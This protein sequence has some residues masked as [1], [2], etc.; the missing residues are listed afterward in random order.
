MSTTTTITDF[1]GR[2]QMDRALSGEVGDF[3]VAHLQLAGVNFLMRKMLTSLTVTYVFT[4]DEKENKIKERVETPFVSKELECVLDGETPTEYYA[5]DHMATHVKTIKFEDGKMVQHIKE[6]G[7]QYYYSEVRYF[8]DDEKNVM[9]IE[10][11]LFRDGQEVKTHR[12]FVR[13]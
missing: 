9:H 5:D 8:G 10:G 13:V 2:F 12:V 7:G 11:H 1:N 3:G 6:K 4:I